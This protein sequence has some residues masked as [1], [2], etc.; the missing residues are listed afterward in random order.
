MTAAYFKKASTL[1]E[2]LHNTS[3]TN[4]VLQ[5]V[6]YVENVW[7]VCTPST[8]NQPSRK[9]QLKNPAVRVSL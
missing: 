7:S 2:H 9:K 8:Q 5:I 3:Y 6:G 4:R 1:F